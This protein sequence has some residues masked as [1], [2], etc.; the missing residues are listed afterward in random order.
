MTIAHTF[1]S[2]QD[3]PVF[4]PGFKRAADSAGLHDTNTHGVIAKAWK[5]VS[6]VNSP[7]APQAA[8]TA[9]R[10]EQQVTVAKDGGFASIP[11]SLAPFLKDGV[12]KKAAQAAVDSA[13]ELNRQAC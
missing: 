11:K 6:N 8:P 13:W 7:G 1:I 12:K 10:T 3:H 4:K 2:Q 9:S 5:A